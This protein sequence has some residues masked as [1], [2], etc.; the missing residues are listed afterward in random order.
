MVFQDFQGI[1]QGSQPQIALCDA[2]GRRL[3]SMARR[4]F[5]T[6]ITV[7]RVLMVIGALLTLPL[8]LLPLAGVFAFARVLGW[9]SDRERVDAIKRQGRWV[10]EKDFQG[11]DEPGTLIVF[12][13]SHRN[14]PSR[15][16]CWWTP[17]DIESEYRELNPGCRAHV[18]RSAEARRSDAATA[19]FD[20]WCYQTFLSPELGTAR[21]L[22]VTS[23]AKVAERLRRARPRAKVCFILSPT[24]NAYPNLDALA[25]NARVTV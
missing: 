3:K 15:S 22:A 16:E 17:V 25:P 24:L 4:I 1:C 23:G 18:S 21:M 14:H 5:G 20:A 12:R 13:K 9:I 2:F 10:L 6:L 7:D 19:E 11:S 8:W